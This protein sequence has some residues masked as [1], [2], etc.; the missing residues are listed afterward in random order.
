MKKGFIVGAALAAAMCGN[1]ENAVITG[2]CGALPDSTEVILFQMLGQAGTSIARD[3]VINGFFRLVVPVDSGLMKTALGVNAPQV[4]S[5]DR[6]IYLRPG[7]EV[8]VEA[9]DYNIFTWPVR[10]AVPEQAE[11]DRFLTNSKELWDQYQKRETDYIQA[12]T[13]ATDTES[14]E[15]VRK[16]YRDNDYIGDS[17]MIAIYRR[18][19]ALLRK[20]PVN[21]SWLAKA[22]QLARS[23]EFYQKYPDS[24]TDELKSLF[25]S[26][27]EHVKTSE[28]GKK[29]EILLYPPETAKRGDTVPDGTFYDLAGNVHHLADFRG[30]W[31]L[32]D[33]W[34]RGC[35]ACVMAIPELHEFANKYADL[36][37][38]ISLSLDSDEMWREASASYSLEGNN[39]NEGKEDLGLYRNF[40]AEGMP[41]FVLVSP[42]GIVTDRFLGYSK[43]IF[44][45][46]IRFHTDSKDQ[47]SISETAGTRTIVRPEYI[48]NTTDFVLDIERIEQTPEGTTISFKVRYIPGWWIKIDPRAFLADSAGKQYKLTG[49]H[50]ITPGEEFTAD[51]NGEGSFSLTFEPIP[52]DTETVDFQ[53]YMGSNWRITGIRLK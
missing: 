42:E 48:T 27:D 51:K 6:T 25:N 52:A 26:L 11:Y 33:F 24:Y 7:A 8:E 5:M 36:A 17:I 14:R 23:H 32:L 30:K 53:E 47:K 46:M 39:W 44:D 4:P 1:A 13:A 29:I 10:S 9:S 37:E 2:H 41:T 49:S 43:G 3:T 19:I 15:A 50:G 12:M 40:G 35:Y 34:S 38:V 20:L 31:L 28:A 16:A 18:D 21:A 45:R 22:E